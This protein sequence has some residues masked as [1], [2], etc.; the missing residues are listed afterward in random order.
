M[1]R[2]LYRKVLKNLRKFF[3]KRLKGHKKRRLKK[4]AAFICGPMRTKRPDMRSVGSG[5]PQMVRSCSKEKGAKK[6]PGNKWV[7]QEGYYR[8]YIAEAVEKIVALF[9][10]NAG[11]ALVV[12]GS[13]MGKG[14]MAL[15]ASL[16]FHGRGLPW[17]GRWEK[18]PKGILRQKRMWGC[19]KR[20]TGLWPPLP[21]PSKP[22]PVLGGGE[23][24]ST[25]LQ[26]ACPSFHWGYVFRT[27]CDTALC[28]NGNRFQPRG[29]RP[30]G[31]QKFLP[32]PDVEST[33]KKMGHVHFVLWH[34]PK[35]DGPIPL[36]SNLEGPLILSRHMIKGIPL[37]VCPRT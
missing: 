13:K 4:P 27:A 11:I 10:K 20:R 33:E 28:E 9:P 24:D 37:N 21:P 30:D 6:P 32:A 35:Y 18:S 19:S 7:D 5:L 17:H 23:F 15:M 8:P 1:K 16:F 22:V 2:R 26:G 25:E 29:L 34:D 12:D 3:G 36:A 31:P 14:H